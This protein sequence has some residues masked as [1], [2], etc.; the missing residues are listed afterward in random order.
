MERVLNEQERPTA[1]VRRVDVSTSN[2]GSSAASARPEKAESILF[3]AYGKL[4]DGQV[5]VFRV[6]DT[7][8]EP[9]ACGG[10]LRIEEGASVQDGVEAH[11]Q[12]AL[13]QAWRAWREAS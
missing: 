9:C 7:R 11:N 2:G 6:M 5:G 10:S 3:R 4:V 12:T 8:V 1:A 13:H